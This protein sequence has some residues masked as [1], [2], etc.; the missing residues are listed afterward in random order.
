M[1][2]NLTG[3]IGGTNH[4]LAS[5]VPTLDDR[6]IVDKAPNGRSVVAKAPNGKSVV[7]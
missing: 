4:C 5:Y 1:A 6:S 3:Y 7:V 2:Q